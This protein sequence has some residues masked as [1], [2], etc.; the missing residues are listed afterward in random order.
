MSVWQKLI[1]H[2]PCVF[3]AARHVLCSRLVNPPAGRPG[4]AGGG[5]PPPVA[6][7]DGHGHMRVAQAP[8]PIF[9]E[10]GT[11]G[12]LASPW[13]L[14]EPTALLGR[15]AHMHSPWSPCLQR[16]Q[17]PGQRGLLKP[18][19]ELRCPS[20]PSSSPGH[21]CTCQGRLQAQRGQGM[22]LGPGMGSMTWRV[23]SGISV[24]RKL[25]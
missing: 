12:H 8:T 1:C 11:A 22:Q 18:P 15:Q 20:T 7:G 10:A 14:G 21:A 4:R 3:P 13:S 9:G 16:Q 6:Q 5:P 24:I 2:T 19:R 17:A 23:W 25:T